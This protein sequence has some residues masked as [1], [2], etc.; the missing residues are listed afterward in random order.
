VERAR[1]LLELGA[2]ECRHGDRAGARSI[3]LE[4]LQLATECGATKLAE[5]A[6]EEARLAGA[7]PRRA[8]TTGRAALTP[9][10]RRVALL[11]A[12]GRTNQEIAQSLFVTTKTVKAHLGSVYR[13][14]SISTRGEL[15]GQL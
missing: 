14:L 12:D 4:G 13:R 5:R 2:S 15:R 10:E 7:R 8:W 3:L 6:R 9:A 1:S 11:A